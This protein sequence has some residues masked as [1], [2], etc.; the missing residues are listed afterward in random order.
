MGFRDCC[1]PPEISDY[2]GYVSFV[3]QIAKAIGRVF[4]SEMG[5]TRVVVNGFWVDL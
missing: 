4:G 2:V 1:S 3:A 5:V